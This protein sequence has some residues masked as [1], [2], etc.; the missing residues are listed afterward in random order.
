LKKQNKKKLPVGSLLRLISMILLVVLLI[1]GGGYLNRHYHYDFSALALAS[2]G[3]D[4]QVILVNDGKKMI[5]ILDAKGRIQKRIS[6]E[7]EDSFYYADQVL[8]EGNVIYIADTVYD[9]ADQ[10]K[11]KKRLLALTDQEQNVLFE[12][13][14]DRTVTLDSDMS[15]IMEFQV[16]NG[17]VYFLLK[18]DYGL[19]L[20][21]INKDRKQPSLLERYYCGDMLNDASIDLQSGEV[22]IAVRRGFVRVFDPEK[23]VWETLPFEGEH[24]MPNLIQ[25]R[26]RRVYF[27][28]LYENQLWLYDLEQKDGFTEFL[29]VSGK[30]VSLEVSRDGNSV[31]VSNSIG[32][33]TVTEQGSGY[34]SGANYRFFGVTVALWILLALVVF[35]DLWILYWLLKRL[36]KHLRK[37]NTIRVVLVVMATVIVSSFVA[38]SLMSEL[39]Q[40]EQDT[41]ISNIKLFAE[42]MR[43]QT[44]VE[45]ILQMK[46]E[47]FYGTSSYKKLREPLDEMIVKSYEEQKYYYYDLFTKDE[48]GIIHVVDYDDRVMCCE[49]FVGQDAEY[50][51]R[52]LQTGN[53]YALSIVDEEGSWLYV[54]VPV[55]D[56]SGVPIVVLEVG[57]DMSLIEHERGIAI[58]ETALNVVCTTAVVLMLVL[59]GV[60][61]LTFLESKKRATREKKLDLPSVVPLRMLIFFTNAADSLQDAFITILCIQLYQGQL[62]I[63]DS[64][65]VALPLSAQLLMLALFSSF[66]G[67]VGEKKG[68]SKTMGFGLLIQCA[69][70]LCCVLTGSYIG[71]LIG[72][73]MIGSGMGTVYVNS[74]A[75][76]AKGKTEESSS[77]AFA[78]ITAGSLSGVTIG[79]GIASVFLSLGG[80]RMVYLAGTVLLLMAIYVAF[81]SAKEEKNFLLQEKYLL[82]AENEAQKTLQANTEASSEQLTETQPEPQKTME[83]QAKGS[84]MTAMGFL[85]QKRII[86]YFLLI[87]LPFM[88]SLSYREYFLPLI[89]EESGVSEITIGRFYLMCGLAFLYVGPLITNYLMKQLGALRSSLFACLLMG[90][91]LL[92]YVLIPTVTVVFIG[93]VILSFVTAF[94]YGC[95]YTFFGTL[96][97]SQRYGEA[98]SMEVYTVF[99]SIGSTV[100]PLAYGVLL[101]LGSR[102][103]IGIFCG[104]IFAF[105]GMYGMLMKTTK[106]KEQK[107]D[108]KGQDV[109]ESAT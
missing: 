15:D 54:L 85:F 77:N 78:L 35:I 52:V 89:A 13:E 64:V 104:V 96:A 29:K 39:Y 74:Y 72:K 84:G 1:F 38:Y 94:A 42:L 61:Y 51:E 80:W 34:V 87:L 100:G 14:Y 97:E 28:D 11:V 108:N 75:V 93:V 33:Y 102:L 49:P 24:L 20:Y 23:N 91:V 103:G 83:P 2:F 41:M 8:A 76:A 10:A 70:C 55:T 12:Q 16:W 21:R 25:I 22:A 43:E 109:K 7:S 30:P 36:R 18:V 58:R 47:G 40:K 27:S 3:P 79:S 59:E 17:D 5:D 107:T 73:M 19:E 90:M 6:G 106:G 82:R 60:L 86:G 69:G 37:E 62:P 4:G 45:A 101:S 92:L 44:N 57:T 88:M 56:E 31:L 50:Y 71:V 46:D 68:A 98:R 81:S 65:A 99:E 66:M 67:T 48:R 63:P 95:M 9:E 32:F 53:S 105:T 26:D